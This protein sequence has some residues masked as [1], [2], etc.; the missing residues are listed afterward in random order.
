LEG[1][2]RDA[3]KRVDGIRPKLRPIAVADLVEGVV[4]C[5]RAAMGPVAR[6]SVEGIAEREDASTERDFHF[7]KPLGV[8]V[9]VPALMV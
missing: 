4:Q 7:P 9:A 8:A 3:H 1:I 2:A 6:H 5:Q